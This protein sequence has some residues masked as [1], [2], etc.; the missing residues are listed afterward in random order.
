MRLT[1]LRIVGPHKIL[2]IFEYRGEL[3]GKSFRVGTHIGFSK[4]DFLHALE[5]TA[6]IFTL[7]LLLYEYGTTWR[8]HI[9]EAIPQDQW[10]IDPKMVD[11]CLE[12]LITTRSPG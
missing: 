4:A 10:E 1:A 8:D 2:A 3:I 7:D 5:K 9:N 6:R 11:E 12:S